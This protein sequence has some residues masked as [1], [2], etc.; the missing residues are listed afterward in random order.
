[1]SIQA[2]ICAQVKIE[3]QQEFTLSLEAFEAEIIIENLA[4]ELTQ[5]ELE[6]SIV[7]SSSGS[8]AL[9]LFAIQDPTLTGFSNPSTPVNATIGGGVFPLGSLDS[10]AT[11]KSYPS[12]C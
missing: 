2:S 6:F 7:E 10:D 12:K 1:M 9:T 8:E 11:G 3:I 4:S 5:V